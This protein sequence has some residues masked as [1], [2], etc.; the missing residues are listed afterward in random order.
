MSSAAAAAHSAAGSASSFR[1]LL[2]LLDGACAA[3]GGAAAADGEALVKVLQQHEGTFL[4]LLNF[5]VRESAS[6]A[7]SSGR[8]A[9]PG[10]WA[11][12]G[13]VPC[14][15]RR[16]RVSIGIGQDAGGGRAGRAAA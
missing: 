13:G 4:T 14:E 8:V 2:R 9:C 12:R 16:E 3:G 15:Q 1:T 7:F 10:P 11:Q 5:E 6:S